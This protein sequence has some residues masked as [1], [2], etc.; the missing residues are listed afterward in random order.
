MNERLFDELKNI[1]NSNNKKYFYKNC[2]I[3]N[4]L[5]SE[6]AA[7]GFPAYHFDLAYDVK[8]LRTS[9]E[10]VDLLAESALSRMHPLWN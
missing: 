5:C 9:K 7:Q 8:E 4:R 2:R 6:A 1:K 10:I 3:S